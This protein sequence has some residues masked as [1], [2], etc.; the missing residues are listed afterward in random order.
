MS[1][2]RLY[3]L[4]RGFTFDQVMEMRLGDV[5]ELIRMDL[6]LGEVTR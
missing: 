1:W 5:F 3:L 6:F 2:W 4:R